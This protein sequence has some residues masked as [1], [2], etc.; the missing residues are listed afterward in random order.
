[1]VVNPGENAAERSL[2]RPMERV[3]VYC[4]FFGFWVNP[5]KE[6]LCFFHIKSQGY[7]H[8]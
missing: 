4:F 3:N 5:P 1:M 8:F 7:F 6:K 2:C